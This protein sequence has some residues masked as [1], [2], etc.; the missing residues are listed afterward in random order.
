LSEPIV[1]AAAVENIV[2]RRPLESQPV[3]R[4]ETGHHNTAHGHDDHGPLHHHFEDMEQQREATVLG[5]WGFLCTEVMMF[6]GLF[7]VY[8]LYRWSATQRSHD[9]GMMDPFY[10]GSQMLNHTLGLLNTFVLLASSF[11]MAMGVY[12]AQTRNRKMLMNMLVLTWLF[13]AAFLG[14]KAIEWTADWHEGLVPALQ[15][16]PE[17]GLSE[18]HL[19]LN[20][21]QISLVNLNHMQMYF[22]IYFCMTGLHAIHMIIGLGVVGWFWVLAKRGMFTNGNDQPVELVG[23]YWHF[24]DIVWVFLFPLLYLMAG[25]IHG[26]GAH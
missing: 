3:L 2:G 13:G 7:F 4:T 15:W 17:R 12:F 20:A 21:E 5:M 24:V 16:F 6:G 26:G 22:V 11:T 19:H 10:V 9:L 14:I 18:G 23:M 25:H 8:T 1:R